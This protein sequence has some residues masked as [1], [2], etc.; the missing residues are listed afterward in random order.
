MGGGE[1]TSALACSKRPLRVETASSF[2]PLN[3]RS[4]GLDPPHDWRDPRT[5]YGRL[6]LISATNASMRAYLRSQTR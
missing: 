5:V 4:S 6:L 3:D 1:R 2:A